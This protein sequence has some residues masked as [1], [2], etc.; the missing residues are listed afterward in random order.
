MTSP[1]PWRGAGRIRGSDD[2]ARALATVTGT[3]ASKKQNLTT[4]TPAQALRAAAQV[5]DSGADRFLPLHPV[6]APLSPWAGGL[7]RGSTVAVTGSMSLLYAVLAP[8]IGAGGWAAVVGMPDLG[9]VAA[10]EHDGLDLSRL[11][12]VPDP[13]T[14]WPAILAVLMDGV[15]AVAIRPR[16]GV[17]DATAR[18]LVARARRTGT[19]LIPTGR[20]PGADLN[21]AASDRV[22]HGLGQGRGRLKQM[23]LTVTAHGRGAAARPRRLTTPIPL[24]GPGVTAQQRRPQTWTTWSE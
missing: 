11:A 3:A 4:A 10:A 14:D 17:T 22:W 23:T 2:V 9:A 5:S 24:P 20:W 6:L 19:I 18:A 15:D 1:A 21:L 7:R 12:L 16:G 13:G 8:I